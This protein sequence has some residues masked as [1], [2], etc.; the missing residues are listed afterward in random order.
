MSV[1]RDP[2][3]TG[4][5]SAI[6]ASVSSRLTILV[7]LLVSILLHAT[8][9]VMF[10]RAREKEP[11]VR[12]T[13]TDSQ[14]DDAQDDEADEDDLA[15]EITPGITDGVATTMTWIGYREYEEHLARLA[16]QDQAAMTQALRAG[17][18]TADD[19]R[20][21]APPTDAARVAAESSAVQPPPVVDIESQPAAPDAEREPDVDLTQPIEPTSDLVD[22]TTEIPIAEVEPAFDPEPERAAPESSED[23]ET[24]ESN[25]EPDPESEST[26]VTDALADERDRDSAEAAVTQES[27]QSPSNSDE[28][29][30]A[31]NTP[32]QS[33]GEAA[34]TQGEPVDPSA[35][36]ADRDSSATSTQKVPAVKW[37][38]GKPQAVRGVEL[39]PYSLYRHVRFDSNDLQ[40]DMRWVGRMKQNPVVSLRFDRDGRVASVSIDRYSGYTYFDQNYLKTWLSRWTARDPRLAQLAPGQMTYPITLTLVFIPEPPPEGSPEG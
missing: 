17:D 7:A 27:E 26:Q 34:E 21:L 39:R 10:H 19:P 28:A 29:T 36:Q 3:S 38:N 6:T 22:D 13:H 33:T 23:A 30:P 18:P 20:P 37:N 15:R 8:T 2:N 9:L 5:N 24:P 40:F 1:S 14:G 11:N 31:V 25:V 4:Y 32:T 35:A 12:L 16:D